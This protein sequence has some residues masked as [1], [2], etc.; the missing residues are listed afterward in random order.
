MV[1]ETV[2]EVSRLRARLSTT[3][4]GA[5]GAGLRKLRET[6]TQMKGGWVLEVDIKEFLDSLDQRAPA[7][8]PRPRVREA[9][10]RSAIDKWLKA[11]IIEEGVLMHPA[12]GTPRPASSRRCWRTSTGMRCSTGGSKRK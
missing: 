1:L 2:Y 6:V 9:V 12:A 4:V 3:A 7:R 8:V 10:L 11:G 5:S